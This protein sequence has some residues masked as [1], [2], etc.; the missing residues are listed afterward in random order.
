LVT[1]V[2]YDVYDDVPETVSWLPFSSYSCYNDQLTFAVVIAI[3]T[4]RHQAV[5]IRR[6]YCT[7][8]RPCSV[9]WIPLIVKSYR[10]YCFRNC[11][12]L[13]VAVFFFR[14]IFRIFII[15]VVVL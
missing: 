3:V 7:I 13:P 2:V 15:I 6:T 5:R 1:A 11:L 14:C 10:Y 4:C 12:L 9:W 8:V